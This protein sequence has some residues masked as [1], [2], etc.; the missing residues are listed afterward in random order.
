MAL[1]SIGKFGQVGESVM[2]VMVG[3]GTATPK[4]TRR[5]DSLFEFLRPVFGSRIT[6]AADRRMSYSRDWSLRPATEAF[7]P[8]MVV[9]PETAEQ[10]KVVI[11][12]AQKF[13]V[14][15]VPFSGGTGAAGGAV[16]IHG[17]V[18]VD[19]KC[20][21]VISEIDT[22][23]YTVTCGA[24]TVVLA[25]TKELEKQGFWL[26]QQTESKIAATVGGGI[27]CGSRAT[28]GIRYG[29]WTD[30][31]LNGTFVTGRGDIINIGRRKATRSASGYNLLNLLVNSEGTL[32]IL[33]EATLRIHR[34]PPVRV[35]EAFL[36]RSVQEAAFGL[37][38]LLDIGLGIE[39]GN[40][41]C[42]RRL[43]TYTHDYETKHG[44]PPDVPDWAAAI[45]FV[46][47]AGTEEVVQF[48]VD[49][50]KK[51]LK[52]KFDAS[53]FPDREMIDAWWA[54]KHSLDFI[55]YH[56][57]W[58]DSQRSKKHC[59]ADVGIPLGRIGEAYEEFIRVAGMLKLEILGMNVY[60]QSCNRVAPSVSFTVAIED[61]N[62]A[63]VQAFRTYLRKMGEVALRLGG[64]Q[65]SALGDGDR[66][67][68]IN[69]L[70][71][72]A[73]L[74]YMRDLKKIFD[75][76]WIMNPGKK[77]QVLSAQEELLN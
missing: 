52:L 63:E 35:V 2:T 64:T 59:V 67:V 47:I 51:A 23:S 5:A 75:P 39:G 56:Q 41:N 18:A 43:A 26:P 69:N 33:T 31:I 29:D 8:D 25:L 19:L 28:F 15:V 22:E 68:D 10:V 14:P 4:R 76:H 16:A 32:G 34:L 6:A 71:H 36:F 27:N 7:L 60:N 37:Q 48:T 57:K 11:D 77:L 44:H 17:G 65:S 38:H 9:L 40:I 42:R 49:T 50:A 45:L 74:A 13:K 70:E 58:P 24:G 53:A 3:S 55:P 46:T 20:L 54:I 12:A 72:G 30:T 66:I 62:D 73:S 21:N 1:R 61:R